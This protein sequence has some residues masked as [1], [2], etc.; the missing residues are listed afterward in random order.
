[1]LWRSI[2]LTVKEL[3]PLTSDLYLEILISQILFVA[4]FFL[5]QF[6]A[7]FFGENV[8]LVNEANLISNYSINCKKCN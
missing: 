3:N 1:M 6:S 8:N 4:K 5:S 7:S 2:K